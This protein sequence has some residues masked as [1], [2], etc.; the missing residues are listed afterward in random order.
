M[1]ELTISIGSRRFDFE[2]RTAVMGIV[3]VTPDSFSDGGLFFDT[4]KAITHGLKLVQDGADLLDIG[5]E[6]T[7]PGSA[8]V[9]MQEELNRVI[10]VIRELSSRSDVPISIDTTKARVAETALDAGASWVNDIS[11]MTF[12][13]DMAPLVAQRRVPVV[14]MHTA[15]RPKTMQLTFQYDNVV[16]EV[17][18]YLAE[19]IGDAVMAGIRETDIVLDPGIGFGKSVLH[20]IELIRGVKRLAELGR[21]ILMGT[22]RKSFIG[23]ILDLPVT[24]RLEGSLAALAA[25]CLYGAS[26]IRVHDVLESVRV[27]KMCDAI[28]GKNLIAS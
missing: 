22:S 24:E 13:P 5:G 1:R 8:S 20:N 9:S 19:R 25:S 6:S 27:C 18:S 17:Y 23:A 16:E 26:I 11:A 2:K 3:N 4:E 7:R 12:D 15:D 14:L 28:N 21:P 10:P